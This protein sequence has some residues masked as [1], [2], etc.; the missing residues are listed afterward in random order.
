MNTGTQP[1]SKLIN[2]ELAL[3]EGEIAWIEINI[4]D[5]KKTIVQLYKSFAD[6]CSGS[7]VAIHKGMITSKTVG[8]RCREISQIREWI[9]IGIEL[10]RARQGRFKQMIIAHAGTA[11]MFHKLAI[12]DCQND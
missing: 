5:L 2:G 12:V 11:A 10:L 8:Q 6:Y 1:V 3:S 9:T 4:S 7:L